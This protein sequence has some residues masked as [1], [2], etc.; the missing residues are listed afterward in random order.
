MGV[1]EGE[2]RD[3]TNQAL[4]GIDIIPTDWAM[5]CKGLGATTFTAHTPAEFN[6]AM[7]AAKKA[8]GP[9]VI[10]VKYT[11]YMPFTTVYMFLDPETQPKDKVNAFVKKYKAQ[12]LRPF[13]HFL[14][15]VGDEDPSAYYRPKDGFWTTHRDIL[16]NSETMP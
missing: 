2:Q 8:S 16:G 6:E 12:D 15:E 7:T 11:H 14:K 9:V 1:I 4:S 10:D 5:A 3:D 13:T